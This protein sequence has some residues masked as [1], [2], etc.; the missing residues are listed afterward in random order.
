MLKNATKNLMIKNIATEL[1]KEVM[2]P[3]AARRKAK[4]MIV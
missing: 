2:T 4:V 1:L 3:T